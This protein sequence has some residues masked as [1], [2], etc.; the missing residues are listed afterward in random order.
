MRPRCELQKKRRRREGATGRDRCRDSS[1]PDFGEMISRGEQPPTPVRTTCD[2]EAPPKMARAM[3]G[4]LL[5][6]P[7]PVLAGEK[8]ASTQSPAVWQSSTSRPNSGSMVV[9]P[10]FEHRSIF[11]TR[12]KRG[13]GLAARP[14][15]QIVQ[16]R[17]LPLVL[18]SPS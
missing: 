13:I 18:G 4:D 7:V 16:V 2:V 14:N 15:S 12:V 11:P 6:M 1:V 3:Y 8:F 17:R 5:W 10:R 9:A